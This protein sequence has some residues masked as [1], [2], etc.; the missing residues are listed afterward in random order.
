MKPDTIFAVAT[1]AG[2]AAVA[3][4][5][6]SGSRSGFALDALA[7]GRPPPRMAALR[8]LR[9]LQGGEPIDHALVLWFPAPASFTGEDGAELHLHGSR[10]VVA[11]VL[12]ALAALPGCRL[13][14][15]GEFTRRAFLNGKM[16]LAAVEGLADL[17][18]AQT[19]AQRRQALRQLDGALGRWVSVQR[20]RLLDALAA[21]ESAIDFSDEG[22]VAGDFASEVRR[23]VDAIRA[24]IL[25]ELGRAG[26]AERLR[27]GFVV[28]IAGPP[29]AGK[30]TLLNA[31]ARR[32]VAI[33]SPH[34]GTTRDAIALDLDLD[35]QLVELI[36]TAGLRE[37]SDPIEREGIART[38]AR[39]QAAD[40]ILWLHDAA[41][42]SGPDTNL[43]NAP[44]LRVA[45][46]IDLVVGDR[47]AALEGDEVRVSA[48]SGEGL[49]ALV[50]AIAARA[51]DGLAGASEAVATRLRHREALRR[52]AD[53]LERIGIAD[54]GLGLE[55]VADDLRAVA[56]ELDA[57]IGRIDTEE[58]LG[59]IFARFCVGK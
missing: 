10:A 40:L 44:T 20:E 51:S 41:E 19:E 12:G 26:A 54:A 53:Y 30:S 39:A 11:A 45:T 43:G 21:A 59:A 35:G 25:V 18:D 1:G 15:P 46:K 6:L 42:P 13:A 33:V 37:T 3:I 52:A 4:V 55:L 27:S 48:L 16:D 32:E 9:A 23:S 22:D 36:D 5:R 24:D 7:G 47:V 17:I 49:P 34:A 38:R 57:L 31:L 50:A 8:M 14:E 29:N 2:R 56:A 28:V 58:V